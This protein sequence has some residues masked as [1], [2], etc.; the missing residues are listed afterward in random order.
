MTINFQKEDIARI[1][2][3]KS[4]FPIS[5]SKKIIND[6]LDLMIEIINTDK[7]NLKNFGSFKILN[8]KSRLGRNPKTKEKFIISA[9]KTLTF[10]TSKKFLFEINN[11]YKH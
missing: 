7:L 9:R 6:L 11:N 10:K 8:K 3:V 4:G 5:Y 1:L 2:S